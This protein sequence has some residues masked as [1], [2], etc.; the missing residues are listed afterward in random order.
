VSFL[1]ALF[2]P[3]IAT[4][5]LF[6]GYPGRAARGLAPARL[7]TG[8]ALA[9]GASTGAAALVF[10]GILGVVVLAYRG[11][12]ATP[13]VGV[14]AV[15]FWGTQFLIAAAIGAVVGALSA[16]ALLPWVRG[17]LTRAAPTPPTA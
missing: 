4:V 12:E 5:I 9:M 8:R 11:R 3:V 1:I 7:G 6:Q 10:L 13:Q 15:V 2:L 17:R 14:P 16:L